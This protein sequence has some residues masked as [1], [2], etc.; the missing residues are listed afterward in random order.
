[1]GEA[2]FLGLRM[3]EGID[4]SYFKDRFGI[5][6]EEAYPDAVKDLMEDGLLESGGGHLRLTKKGILFL[7]DVSVRF[8]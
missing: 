2:V 8:V 3:M 7:N 6:I 1:M 4:L 5:G